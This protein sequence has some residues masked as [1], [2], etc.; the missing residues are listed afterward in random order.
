MR[1]VVGGIMHESNTFLALRTGRRAFEAGSLTRGD[2]MVPAW[3]DAHHELGGFIEG[4]TR[5]GFDLLPTVM[6]WATPSGP[7]DDALLDDVI[8]ELVAGCRRQP[9]DGVLLALHGAMVTER[10]PSADTEVL[11]RVR[12]ALGTAVPLIA[13]LDFHANATPEMAQHADALVGYQTNPHV[14]QRE[15]GLLAAELIARAARSEIRPVTALAKPPLIVNILAQDTEREPLRSLMARARQAEQ[16]SGMLS[17]SIMAGFPYADVLDMGPSVIAVAN[18]DRSQAEKVAA[19]L[20]QALWDVR[21]ELNITCPAP[22]DAVRMAVQA[23]VWPVVLVDVGDNVGGGSAGDGTALLAELLRQ[24]ASGAV[25]TLYSPDGVQAATQVGIGG[26]LD[27]CLGGAVDRH[28]GDPVAIRGVVH[29][30]H[31]GKW[32]ESEVRHGGR[33][34]NDQGPT[35]VLEIDGPNLLVLNSLRTPPFSLGQ[36]TSLGIDPLRQRILVVKAAIAY[37][38]AYGPIAARIIEV[39]TPGLTAV[40]AARLP[41]GK[42]R[43]PIYPLDPELTWVPRARRSV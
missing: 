26:V 18:G 38:A 22:A 3:Q 6:A 21:Q 33:R 5:C 13:T 23:E 1:I 37:K 28:H 25:L 43:R 34:H 41:Y 42:I 31:D 9:I 19:E 11:R 2:A 40:N 20:A 12:E 7:V 10:F 16:R 36:L 17:V 27:N 4:A 24:N 29:S 32:V 35:A 14:D 39:D 15:R 8:S 30:L